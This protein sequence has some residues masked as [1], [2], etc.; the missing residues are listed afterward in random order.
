MTCPVSVTA[1][2]TDVAPPVDLREAHDFIEQ[3]HAELG[4]PV[5]DG[6]VAEVTRSVDSTGTYVHTPDELR[7]ACRVA[8][9]QAEK[10]VGRAGWAALN[11]RDRRHVTDAAGIAA[12]TVGHLQESTNG[13]R[14]RPT[15]TVFAAAAPGTRGPRFH[16]E[17]AIRYAGDPRV[18]AL[19]D[20]A[21]ASGWAW[22]GDRWA[23]LPLIVDDGTGPRLFDV[24][25]GDVLEV[26][27]EHPE[28]PWFAGL[29]LRWHA[30][31]AIT[32]MRLEAG[33]LWYPAIPFSGWYAET[34]IAAR[35][36]SDVD[37]YNMLPVI[38]DLLGLD[39][40]SSWVDWRDRATLVLNEA[41]LWSFQR[42]KVKVS[43]KRPEAERLLAFLAREEAAGRGHLETV[44]WTWVNPPTA[45]PVATF[46]RYYQHQPGLRPAL[47]RNQGIVR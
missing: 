41:V 22:D 44:D 26:H 3:C 38:A 31:P 39:P 33:G 1:P 13:G 17:Q 45:A 10:C 19:L 27:L 42:A 35:N 24:P 47:I 16:N 8:W 7:W 37:R 28:H 15:A 20:E 30:L 40:E 21:Q 43:A 25:R 11:V 14:I 34:E 36:L 32:D 5:P 18:A 29:G 6:R 9:R 46:H 4:W 2:P 23:V 12:D